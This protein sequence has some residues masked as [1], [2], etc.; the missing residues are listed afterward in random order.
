MHSILKF[1]TNEYLIEEIASTRNIWKNSTLRLEVNRDLNARKDSSKKVKN[2]SSNSAIFYTNVVYDS[3][4][5]ISIA[6]CVMYYQSRIT[7]KTWN[8]EIDMMMYNSKLYAIEKV[9]KWFKT[10]HSTYIWIF[11]D[12]QNAIQCIKKSI[13][14]LVN[15]IYETINRSLNTINIY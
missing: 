13:H 14:F 9:I 4:T 1:I 6:S 15:K 8:L 7:Y 3:K 12:N 11:T 2:I 10:L 5:K